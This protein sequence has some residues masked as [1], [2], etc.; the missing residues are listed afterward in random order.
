MQ[1]SKSLTSNATQLI[2]LTQTDP[3]SGNSYLVE[4]CATGSLNIKR[5]SPGLS[6]LVINLSYGGTVVNGVDV[7]PL[8]ASVII[9]ANQDSVLLNIFP[10]MDLLYFSYYGFTARRN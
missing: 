9:P 4:G 6:P 2:N 8:P 1:L 3:V 7:Q 10:I 5:Q